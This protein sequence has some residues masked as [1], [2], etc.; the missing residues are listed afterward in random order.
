MEMWL[1][2][3]GDRMRLPITPLFENSR[4]MNNVEENLNEVGTVNL[5]GNLGLWNLPISSFFPSQRTEG[6][7]ES[8]DTVY[9]PYHYV[10]LL[11]QWQ[12]SKEPVR[13]II[14]ETSVNFEALIG[15]FSYSENDGSGDVY[16][17]FTLKEYRRVEQK[18]AEVP[19]EV[20]AVA[21]NYDTE[22]TMAQK[23]TGDGENALPDVEPGKFIPPKTTVIYD[24]AYS[25]AYKRKVITE[26]PLHQILTD[27]MYSFEAKEVEARARRPSTRG[28]PR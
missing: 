1:V 21:G 7:E 22:W 5:A 9:D 10:R 4:N 18:T 2:H 8:S 25:D 11:E 12:E 14:T 17:S 19:D 3:K 26:K 27:Y 23:M 13:V 20:T 15:S 24:K 16:Y 28:A 6:V